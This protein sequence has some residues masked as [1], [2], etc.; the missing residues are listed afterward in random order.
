[1]ID[2]L[3]VYLLLAGCFVFG[4]IVLTELRP[5]DSEVIATTEMAIKPEVAPAERRRQSPRPDEL[6]AITLARPLFSST[7]RPA[8]AANSDAAADNDLADKRLT[9]IVTEPG[10][11][12]AIFAVNGAK[13][14]TLTEGEMVDGW[15]IES[16]TPLEVSLGGPGG[17][18]TLQPKADPNLAQPPGPTPLPAQPAAAGARPPGV[19]P[20]FA[21]VPPNRVLPPNRPIPPNL[22]GAVPP[23][24]A[25]LGQRR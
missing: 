22:P 7:R 5:A 2:R 12:L 18:K 6:L 9:G 1:M 4:A 11:H 25:P 23:R 8:S 24:P 17:N 21:P 16:I 15:R 19:P 13:P 14:L 3:A 20:N 10:K